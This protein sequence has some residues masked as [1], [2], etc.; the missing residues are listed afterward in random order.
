VRFSPLGPFILVACAFVFLPLGRAATAQAAHPDFD[1]V[2][3]APLGCAASP[4]T[5]AEPRTDVDLVG[6]VTFPAV[7]AGQ[8]PTF[9]FFRYRVDGDPSGPRGFA[10]NSAW[11]MIV[12]SPAGSPF[13]YQ[14]QL[15]LNGAGQGGDT[16]EIWANTTADDLAFTPAFTDQPESRIFSQVHDLPGSWSTTPLARLLPAA[17]GSNFGGHPDWFIDLA[18]PI[19]VLVEQGV[20]SSPTEVG[21]LLYF[22]ATATHPDRHNRDNLNCRFLPLTTLVVSATITPNSVPANATTAVR[23]TFAA[24]NSGPLAARGLVLTDAGLPSFVTAPTVR[25]SADDPGITWTVIAEEPLDVR[26]DTLPPGATVTVHIDGDVA[27]TCSDTAATTTVSV[28]AT[29]AHPTTA[30]AALALVEVCDGADNDCNDSVDEGGDALCD[31]QSLCTGKETC[32]AVAGCRPGTPLSCDD[33]DECTTDACDR[34]SGCR[35]TGINGCRSCQGVAECGDGN[36]CTTDACESGGCTYTPLTSC[37]AC[38]NAAQCEDADACTADACNASGVCE[39]TPLAGCVACTI[40]SECDDGDPCTADTCGGGRCVS[41]AIAGCQRCTTAAECDDGNACTEDGCPAAVCAHAP[42]PD[43]TGCVPSPEVCG[44]ASDEDCDEL[45]DC[46]DPDCAGHP[47]CPQPAV[48]ICGNCVDDDGDGRL[49]A[50]D[51][52][53]CDEPMP[54]AVAHLML[55]PTEVRTRGDR[56]RLRS[57]Y[58][59]AAP[60]LFD[61]LRQDTTLQLS[62]GVGPL[63]CTTITA[64]RWRRTGGLTF[65]FNGKG[66]EGGLDAGKFRVNRDGN[67]LF[68][69]RARG[70]AL[71]KL[72]G[73]S[74]RLTVRV[75]TACSGSTMALRQR[76][77]GLVFP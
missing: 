63:V 51:P 71:R 13:Q 50:E 47:S 22:P 11:T 70:I 14:Y 20:V 8:D 17:D 15:A 29:N 48:E 44:G 76:R 25:V 31:D 3:W 16:I 60:P 27:P 30:D 12:Q 61:P 46:A 2:I 41:T 19:G 75:G 69:A 53:C 28:V 54:L 36:P 56:L 77:K 4:L 65:G 23:H 1:A 64:D 58:A 73:G 57:Q 43:C 9:L 67:L 59:L 66:R 38:G 10:S 62:D 68:S 7:Y 18:F 55:R 34:A 26:V 37:V 39:H 33:G 49:D 72:E 45:V 40:A 74:V 6:D 52:R 42:I 32:G 5:A 35:H 24:R 21:K